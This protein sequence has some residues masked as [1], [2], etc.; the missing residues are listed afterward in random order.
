MSVKGK[1]PLCRAAVDAEFAPFCSRSCR[2]RD[3]LN[4]LGD[5]Y[6]VPAAP[7]AE[8]REMSAD[9]DD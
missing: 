8:D 1:C 2:D 4:W 6:R 5:V 7:G 3:L 9:E